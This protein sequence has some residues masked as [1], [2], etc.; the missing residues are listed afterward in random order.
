M[1]VETDQVVPKS[2]IEMLEGREGIL[3]V[4]FLNVSEKE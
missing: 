4:T 1:V 2:A 3:K